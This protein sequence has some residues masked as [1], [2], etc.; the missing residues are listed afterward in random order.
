MFRTVINKSEKHSKPVKTKNTIEPVI[1]RIRIYCELYVVIK[2]KC[3]TQLNVSFL[4]TIIIFMDTKNNINLYDIIIILIIASLTIFFLFRGTNASASSI[5]VECNGEKY[6][7]SLDKDQDIILHGA[8][9][10]LTLRIKDHS[11]AIIKSPCKNQIC[12]QTGKISSPNAFIAC[13]PSKVL[14]V[15]NPPKNLEVDDVAR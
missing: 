13:V 3:N 7:Y 6:R 15:V 4:F 14:V 12:V 2:N 9:G 10:D 5:N 8:I 1:Y 11:A